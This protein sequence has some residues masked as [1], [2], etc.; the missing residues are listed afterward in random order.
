MRKKIRIKKW[1]LTLWKSREKTADLRETDAVAIGRHA[2]RNVPVEEVIFPETLS[3]I[4]TEAF[5]RCDR[6]KRVVLPAENSV[7]ISVRAFEESARLHEVVH[8][9]RISSVG[10]SA[11]A[12]CRM[13]RSLHF[14]R[15]LRKIG[16]E[17]FAEC[18]SMEAVNL[19]SSLS[20]LGKAAFRNCTEL[21]SVTLE[22]GLSLLSPALFDGCISLAEVRFPSSVRRIP[23]GAFRSCTALQTLTIPGSVTR[24]GKNA[25]RSCTGLSALTLELG[26]ERIDAG[27][28]ADTPLLRQVFVPRTLKKLGFHAFGSGR[29][30]EEERIVLFAENEYMEKRLRRML[31]LCGSAGRTRVERIGKDLETR[32]RERHRTELEQKPVHLID[33]LESPEPTKPSEPNKS[34]APES[35]QTSP[36]PIETPNGTPEETLNETPAE[37]PDTELSPATSGGKPEEAPEASQN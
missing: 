35:T 6:L 20:F 12:G 32:R 17:A 11:F 30:P 24:I 8:P 18:R 33:S 15:E 2:F 34:D 37:A 26:V 29:A 7:G 16:E 25:F 10:A 31:F 9:E 19:P 14:S 4:K 36:E 5:L 21:A 22:E 28:F 27:A 1:N 13:L 23:T 3:A